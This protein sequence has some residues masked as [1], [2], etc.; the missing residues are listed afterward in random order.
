M[1]SG[2]R[3]RLQARR[4]T[5]TARVDTAP[6]V[7]A[8]DRHT[9]CG[10]DEDS[11]SAVCSRASHAHEGREGQLNIDRGTAAADGT[12]ARAQYLPEHTCPPEDLH[13]TNGA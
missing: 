8:S 2:H 13:A 11:A 4:N 3:R 12:G 10:Q 7:W 5:G 1:S 9:Q 6:F